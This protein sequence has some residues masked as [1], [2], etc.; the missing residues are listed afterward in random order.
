MATCKEI[1]EWMAKQIEA[2]KL[3]N[4][5]LV[6]HKHDDG[7]DDELVNYSRTK[8]IHIG[9]EAVR[10]ISDVLGLPL[11]ITPRKRDS[12]SPYEVFVLYNGE[13]FFGIETEDE[14]K[15]RGPIV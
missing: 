11:C 12:E 13:I 9:G 7:I 5:T 6:I 8:D 10:Y 3:M 14:Y 2:R 4:E 15:E 1:R